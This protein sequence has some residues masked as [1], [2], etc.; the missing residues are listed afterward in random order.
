MD[1]ADRLHSGAARGQGRVER[2]HLFT[3]SMDETMDIGEDVGEPVSQDYG[4]RDNA[5]TGTVKWV[6]ID[7]DG[8]AKDADHMVRAEERYRLAM[9]RQ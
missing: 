8:A 7:I 3:F 6:Q 2:T 9:A 5:F 1:Q 4:P